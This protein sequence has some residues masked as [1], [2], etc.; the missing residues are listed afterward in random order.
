MGNGTQLLHHDL[1]LFLGGE[2]FHDGGLDD[3]HQGHVAVCGHGDGAQQVRGQLAGEPDGGGAV[4]AAD[5]ADSAGFSGG[6]AEEEVGPEEGHEN[7]ELRGGAQQ[8]RLGVG[9]EGA[10]VG[11][12]AHADEDQAGI[13]AELH[14]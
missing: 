6:E 12:R 7:T 3:G 9:D 13:N 2:R 10:E 14:A 5:D 1:A 4:R 8:Q 11:A